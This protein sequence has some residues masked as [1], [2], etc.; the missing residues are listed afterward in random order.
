MKSPSDK[1]V[2]GIGINDGSISATVNGVRRKEYELWKNMIQRV[3]LPFMLNRGPSYVGCSVS[4][5]FKYYHKF[6]NWCQE[7]I[8]FNEKDFALDKDLLLKG[9]KVYSENICVFIPH[10]LNSLILFNNARR[11][12]C[13]VGV[14]NRNDRYIAECRVHGVK[15]HIGSFD[16]PELAFNAYKEVKEAYIKELANSFINKIDPRAYDAL[17]NYSVH[18]DD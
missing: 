7:Q 2:A 15:K 11:G 6:Y 10:E 4:D 5:T 18:I 8:G 3:Y 12:D 13:P 1:L 9:N 17:L 16:T 14:R